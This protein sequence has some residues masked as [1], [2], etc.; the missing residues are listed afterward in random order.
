M[1]RLS[2]NS[3]IGILLLISSALLAQGQATLPPETDTQNWNDVYLYVPVAGP[4][5]FVMQGTLRL[6][7]DISKPVDERIG[8][9]FSF[10]FGKYLT[11]IPNYLHIR[12]QP[13][14]NRKLYENRLSV[15]ATVKFPVGKFTLSDRNLFERRLR[16]PG[17]DST[18]YRN[19]FQVDHPIGPAK[20]KLSVFLSDEVFYD[21]SFDQW[22]RNRF[23]IGVTKVLSKHL[24]GDL[25]YLRQN[26]SHALPGDLHVI[27]TALRIRM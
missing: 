1:K 8:A 15:A 13:F 2:V 27:G 20:H 4:V 6:G 21:W 18:R 26:D 23:A 7:R 12:T 10:R 19:R 14:A 16:H 11:V 17:G 3:I 24:T 9:G 5:D 25:Y 22:V